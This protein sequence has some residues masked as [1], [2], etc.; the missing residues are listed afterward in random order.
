VSWDFAINKIV[1]KLKNISPEKIGLYLSGQLLNEDYYIANKLGKGF[2]KTANVDTNSRTCMAS[3][4]VGYKKSIGLDHVPTTSE[5]ALNSDLYI[6]IGSNMS[7]AH[8]VLFKKVKKAKKNGLKII[9]IDPVKTEISKIADLHIDIDSGKDLLLLNAIAKKL[10]KKISLDYKLNNLDEY[11]EKIQQVNISENLEKSGVSEAKFN[12]FIELWNSSENIVTSW[13]MGVNQSS[14]GVKTNLAIMNLHLITGKIFKPKNGAFS[15]TGQPNAMGGREVGGLATTLAVHLDYTPENIAKVE[16]FWQTENMPTQ[17]G[18]TAY[19][20]ITKTDLDFLFV[21]HTDPVFHLPNRNL[22][23]S[24]FSKID[25]IVE[26]N[27]YLNSETSQFADLI[28]PA[29]PFGE[30]IGT[31]TNFDRVL[32]KTENIQNKTAESLQDWEIFAKIGQALGFEKEFN[33]NSSDEVF[34]E[35]SQMTKLAPDIDIWKVSDFKLQM[36]FQWGQ[37]FKFKE[38]TLNFHDFEELSEKTDDEYKF[39]LTTGRYKNNWHSDSKTQF[40]HKTQFDVIE[41]NSTNMREL[42][43]KIGDKVRVSSRR[44]EVV[45]FVKENDNLKNNLVFIPLHFKKV[46]Y[47]TSD[48]LDIWSEEPDYKY[49]AVK[50]EKI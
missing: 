16:K 30:K 24:Q 45:V 28:L 10:A 33:F 12:K 37:D 47:L 7:V 40:T 2:L 15:L 43:L 11:L 6:V 34:A 29:S 44:G 1:E 5:D 13:T 41:I 3:A 4:V 31:S 36:P 8:S 25:F 46:N 49:S 14:Q 9:V 38:A 32:T 39:I 17:N 48:I 35:Y 20:M 23:E 18:L 27:S 22:V 50:I 42:N 19:E 21:S 26:I